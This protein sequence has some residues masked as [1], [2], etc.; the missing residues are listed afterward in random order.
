[1]KLLKI[2]VT[3]IDKARLF[4]GKAAT[5]LDL[6]MHENKNGTDKYGNDG[7]ITQSCTKE[8]RQNGVKMPIIGNWK[9]VGA[10]PQAPVDATAPVSGVP[11]TTADAADDQVPF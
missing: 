10:R 2:D 5:Y 7:F 4:K 1:M 6:V 8:E 9:R 3:K 11:S